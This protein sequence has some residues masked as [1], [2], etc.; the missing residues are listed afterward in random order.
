MDNIHSQWEDVEAVAMAVE[1]SDP[2]QPYSCNSWEYQYDNATPLIVHGGAPY[3]HWWGMFET[4]YVPAHVFI[5]HEMKVHYKANSIGSYTANSKIEEMIEDCGECYVDGIYMEGF[6]QEQCCEDFGGTYHGYNDGLDY[7]EIYCEG[8]DAVWS[9][10]CFC[11]GTV[12]SDGDGIADECDDCNNMSGDT[13]DD[14]TVDILDI[15]SVVNIILNGGMNSSNYT[16]CELADANYNADA[17]INVLDIIQIIN[18]ILGSSRENSEL[19]DGNAEIYLNQSGNDLVIT[20]DSAVPVSGVQISF[21]TDESLNIEMK[22]ASND[23]YAA[24]NVYGGIQTFLGFSLSNSPFDGM[25]DI[26]IEDGANL[27]ADD[28]DVIVSTISG[29][30]VSIDWNSL[31]MSSFSID[32]MYPNP[33]NPSTE[34]NYTVEQNG[35]ISVSIYNVL[36]QKIDELY[37]GYQDLGNHKI[38]WNA[39]NLSSGV[40]YINISHENGQSESVKAVLLK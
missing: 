31:E 36:G 6:G 35:N 30:P 4:T 26:V 1:L 38:L 13:N 5:D 22:N 19:A 34:L 9:S 2:G 10:L 39:E 8:S 28:F 16:E 25:L 32:K 24:T 20:L 17:T 29:S 3:Y 21:K 27:K 37:N 11:S 23:L 12:D 7:D 40:Y 14:M 18:L 15:V 33:F